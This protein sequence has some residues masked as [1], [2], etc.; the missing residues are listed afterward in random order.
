MDPRLPFAQIA[1]ISNNFAPGPFNRCQ[2]MIEAVGGTGKDD[3][4]PAVPDLLL[5]NQCDLEHGT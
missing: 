4:H 1:A 2:F 3:W 5:V